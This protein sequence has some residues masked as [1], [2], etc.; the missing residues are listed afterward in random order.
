[1]KY[2]TAMLWAFDHFELYDKFTEFVNCA[3]D[4]DV[5]STCVYFIPVKYKWWQ[6]KGRPGTWVLMVTYRVKNNQS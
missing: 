1:M 4:I 2:N 6:C 5:C 3:Q